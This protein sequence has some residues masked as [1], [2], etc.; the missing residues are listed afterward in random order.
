MNGVDYFLFGF[1]M[2]FHFIIAGFLAS[3]SVR[4]MWALIQEVI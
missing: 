4:L 1:G 3:L 2:G